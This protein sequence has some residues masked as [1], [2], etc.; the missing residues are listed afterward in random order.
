MTANVLK[1]LIQGIE[2]DANRAHALMSELISGQ[3]DAEMVGALLVGFQFRPL[4]GSTLAGFARA[5]REKSILVPVPDELLLHLTDVCGTGGDAQGTFNISTSVAILAA[6]S[7]LPIAKHG[8]RAV[9]S[10]CGSFDV[11]ESLGISFSR[12][13]A[14]AIKS[15][16]EHNIAF[17]FAP[18]FHPCFS[19]LA[20]VRRRLGVR[21][22][23]N[24]LGPLLNPAQVRRQLVGVYSPE[25]VVP[26]AEALAELGAFEVMVVAGEDGADEIS[27]CAPTKVAHL[28]EG[29]ISVHCFQPEDFGFQVAERQDLLG[30][31][32][33]ENGLIISAI[34]A[35]EKGPRREM[36]VMN[37]AAALLVGG[38]VDSLKQG[39]ALAEDILDSGKAAE[40]IDQLKRDKEEAL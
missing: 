27:L 9:S 17:M 34:F 6:A 3:L 36:V 25:L 35:G 16:R 18:S 11:L 30:G 28:R 12:E 22:V 24:I 13:P 4:S 1:D 32:A 39:V 31:S 23:L 2:I 38:R 40:L 14:D 19:S 29:R 20:T 8:N 26:M 33:Q 7:G 10:R 5:F 15:L 37:T 21:T